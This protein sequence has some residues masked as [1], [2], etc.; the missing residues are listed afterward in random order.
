MSLT[1]NSTTSL[2]RMNKRASPSFQKAMR[3]FGIFSI[4]GILVVLLMLA[5]NVLL[6]SLLSDG[7]DLIQAVNVEG[8]S[9]GWLNGL[10]I[11]REFV[12][13]FAEPLSSPIALIFGVAISVSGAFAAIYLASVASDVQQQQYELE[14]R[15]VME[16]DFDEAKTIFINAR[17]ALVR[18]RDFVIKRD[19]IIQQ[20]INL[21]CL[22]NQPGPTLVE[23]EEAIAEAALHLEMVSVLSELGE[24][25][26][27]REQTVLARLLSQRAFSRTNLQFR[28][29]A[30]KEANRIAD[31]LKKKYTTHNAQYGNDV[32]T[33]SSA[34]QPDVRC[35][36]DLNAQINWL[37][38]DDY[39][40]YLSEA[41]ALASP[42]SVLTGFLTAYRIIPDRDGRVAFSVKDFGTR[43]LMNG[44]ASVL[45]FHE[46]EALKVLGPSTLR[47]DDQF[48]LDASHHMMTLATGALEFLRLLLSLPRAETDS[49]GQVND[50]FIRAACIEHVDALMSDGAA[51]SAALRNYVDSQIAH[52]VAVCRDG[53]GTVAYLANFTIP[54]LPLDVY[55]IEGP[56]QGRPTAPRVHKIPD[57]QP[58]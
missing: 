5:L 36:N 10:V 49:N 39:L 19:L 48:M 24:A 4:L 6:L 37:A 20:E 27:A 40:P 23:L 32:L 13:D 54:S 31:N 26:L 57:N 47:E 17:T 50:V 7:G 3:F 30:E 11:N 42:K 38:S 9:E 8:A 58:K 53:L 45:G 22:L 44:C 2:K 51:G 29:A 41:K 25:M 14:L 55:S 16:K 12:K 15:S 56:N 43:D 28:N 33:Y 21:R 1:S 35:R 46:Q 34:M 52:I 18:L